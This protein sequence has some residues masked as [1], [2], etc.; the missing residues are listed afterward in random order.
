VKQERYRLP[1]SREIV[2]GNDDAEL[3]HRKFLLQMTRTRL[4]DARR[5]QNTFE[6]ERLQKMQ[7]ELRQAPSA[8][9][10]DHPKLRAAIHRAIKTRRAWIKRQFNKASQSGTVLAKKYRK[11]LETELALLDD[12]E[13]LLFGVQHRPKSYSFLEYGGKTPMADD[14]IHNAVIRRCLETGKPH[15]IVPKL[16]AMFPEN[17][18]EALAREMNVDSRA[19]L[20]T[21][22]IRA[23]QIVGSYDDPIER[24]IAENYFESKLLRKPLCRL[25]RD[26][27]VEQLGKHFHTH[28][29]EDKYRRHLKSL[30]VRTYS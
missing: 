20:V 10:A 6:V 27:A 24:L 5:D 14:I 29:T 28:I 13:T 2:V 3:K 8:P 30:F 22:R 19:K 11:A 18:G 9:G 21:R 26:E 15:L 17:Y 1:F 23:K 4:R 25:S 12:L 16:A 7:T